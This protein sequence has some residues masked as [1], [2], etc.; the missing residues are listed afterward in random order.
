MLF[1][2]AWHLGQNIDI[3]YYYTASWLNVICPSDPARPTDTVRM[4]DNPTGDIKCS[5]SVY[6]SLKCDKIARIGFRNLTRSML[7]G[8]LK[9]RKMRPCQKGELRS[10]SGLVSKR[11]SAVVNTA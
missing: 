9:N 5:I 6:G 4:K 2:L 10:G 8:M 11:R 7:F 3:A 1:M